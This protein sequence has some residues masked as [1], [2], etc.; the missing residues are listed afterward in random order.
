M[1]PKTVLVIGSG[2]REFAI[3]WMLLQYLGLIK[4]IYIAPG[5][6]GTANLSHCENINIKPSD[7]A[8]L[9][10][11]AKDHQVD[12]TIVGPEDPLGAGLVDDFQVAGLKIF[13]PTQAAAEIELSKVFAK[14]LMAKYGIPTA[15]F[16]VFDDFVAAKRYLH[17]QTEFPLAMKADGGAQGKGAHIVHDLDEALAMVDKIM[18]DLIHGDAGKRIVIEKFLIGKELSVMIISDGTNYRILPITQDYKYAGEGDTGEMTGGMGTCGPLAWAEELLDDIRSQIVEP[19]LN[20]LAS[21]GRPFVGCLYPGLMLTEDGLKVLEVNARFGD[22]EMESV[23]RLLKTPFLEITAA[24]IEGHLG[25]LEIEWSDEYVTSIIIASA[26][27]PGAYNKGMVITGLE[28]AEQIP[29]VVV[30]HAG[31][32][33]EDSQYKTSGGRVLV[34]TAIG[35]NMEE[36]LARAKQAAECIKFEGAWWRHDIG[37]NAA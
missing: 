31:T 28:H 22:P 19:L 26:G 37:K 29:G 21:E 7:K 10:K 4:K 2:G 8:A 12:I 1:S 16:E 11:F 25:D 23:A 3:V 17:Q 5:N 34:V 30:M 24:G 20:A 35:K 27:Y 13:G 14:Q 9:I 33:L 18:V 32:V 36:A 6:G 15:P